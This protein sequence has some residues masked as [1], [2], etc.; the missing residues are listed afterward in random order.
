M[1]AVGGMRIPGLLGWL[2]ASLQTSHEPPVQRE[3]EQRIP[4]LPEAW[5]Q[6]QGTSSGR[7]PSLSGFFTQD[8]K[9]LCPSFAEC[10]FLLLDSLWSKP[11]CFPFPESPN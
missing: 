1:A 8:G 11:S 6:G 2:P 5:I 7:L 3:E 9:G 10:F 4:G